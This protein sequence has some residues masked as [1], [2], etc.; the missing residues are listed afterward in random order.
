MLSEAFTLLSI[1]FESGQAVEGMMMVSRR[2]PT[3]CGDAQKAATR[4]F[5]QREHKMFA[6]HLA[7]PTLFQR[8]SWNGG[9]GC[10]WYFDAQ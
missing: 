10:W 4:I 3:S 5:L 8:V 6:L 2:P 1:T 7:D 9:R